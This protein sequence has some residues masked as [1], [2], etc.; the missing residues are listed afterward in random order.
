M[1]SIFF[2]LWFICII[3]YAQAEWATKAESIS[4]SISKSLGKST[5]NNSSN[6]NDNNSSIINSNYE[7]ESRAWCFDMRKKYGIIP[8]KY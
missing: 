3:D 7:G 4:K 8:G 5:D 1:L 6:N 2:I